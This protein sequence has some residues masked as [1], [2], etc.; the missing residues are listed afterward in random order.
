MLRILLLIYTFEAYGERV[1]A[2]SVLILS[3]APM[4][5]YELGHV[6][7]QLAIFVLYPK[8]YNGDKAKFPP[9]LSTVLPS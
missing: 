2:K 5:S 3:E 8:G 1:M 9:Y 6:V 7:V 4:T